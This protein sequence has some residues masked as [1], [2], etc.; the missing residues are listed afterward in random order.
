MR[1]KGQKGEWGCGAEA[2]ASG[3]ANRKHPK[4][5]RKEIS[6]AVGGLGLDVV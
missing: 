6:M 4:L 3:A 5:M 1:R 2:E